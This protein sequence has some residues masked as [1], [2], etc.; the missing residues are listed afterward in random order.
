M[1][2]IELLSPEARAAAGEIGRRFRAAEPFPHFVF[3]GLLE[4]DFFRRLQQEFP[5]FAARN[6]LNDYG[7]PGGKAVCSDLAKLGPAYRELDALLRSS[8][9]LDWMGEAADTPELLYDPDY[10]GGGTHENLPGESLDSHVDFNLHPRMKWHRRL[11]LILFLNDDWGEDWGG[12]LRLQRNP[13]APAG[14]DRIETVVPRPNRCAVFETSER[15]WHGFERI[16][17]PAEREGLTRRTV[18]VYFYT[19]ER[20][21]DEIVPEHGTYYVPPP[22]PGRYRDDEE[23]RS[24]IEARDRRLRFHWER[25][26]ELR[27]MLWKIDR[28]PSFRV[29]RAL[30]WPL[31]LLRT[32]WKASRR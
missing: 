15:S 22:L 18:A 28:S 2:S 1:A 5:P 20:P 10:Y 19:R 9:F 7:E 16:Q 26:K 30:T 3:D 25:E 17:V 12:C 24:M 14:E 23:L 29:G 6:A 8:D 4:A 31:R 11:N 21:A 27:E 32:A 13:W